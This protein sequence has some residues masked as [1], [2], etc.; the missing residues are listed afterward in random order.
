M[1]EDATQPTPFAEGVWV[2]TQPESVVGMALTVTMTVLR[3]GGGWLLLY[4]PIRMTPERRSAV[5]A[6]GRV[7]HLYL[8]NLFHHLYAGDWASAYPSA[9][10]H[11]PRGLAKKRPDLRI[12]RVQH[13]A[14]EPAFAGLIDELAIDGFRLRESVLVYRPASTLVVAD[15]VHN[16]GRPQG[17]WSKFYT[18]AMG[19]YDRVALSR[20]LRWTAFSDRAAARRSVD[21]LL[22]LP[23]SRLIV[24]HGAPL[25]DGA[26][27]A[28]ANAFNWLPAVAG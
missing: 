21:Q 17:G 15:L 27:E 18:R 25:P 19:F 13:E 20:M 24:G 14:P 11:A 2:D 9:R 26:K 6:L 16:V 23:W 7:E 3:L 5:E 1:T 8:P 22:A 28:V 4:S 12:D 10:L